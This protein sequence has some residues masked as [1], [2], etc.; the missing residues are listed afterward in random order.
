MKLLPLIL[1][2]TAGCAYS[3]SL[4]ENDPPL[5]KKETT[6]PSPWEGL[7]EKPPAVNPPEDPTPGHEVP[8][9]SSP[10]DP[11]AKEAPKTLTPHCKFNQNDPRCL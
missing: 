10:H 1:V 4:L 7:G 9:S 2:L 6:A 3:P 11:P 5:P 8:V